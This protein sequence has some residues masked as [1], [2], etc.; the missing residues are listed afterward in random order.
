VAFTTNIANWFAGGTRDRELQETQAAWNETEAYWRAS[1]LGGQPTYRLA[2]EFM[3]AAFEEAER[4]PPVPISVA[5]S[6]AIDGLLQAEDIEELQPDWGVVAADVGVAS[7][8][9]EMLVR[10]RRW[11]ADFKRMHAIFRE[12]V[13]IAWRVFLN[14]LPESCYDPSTDSEGSFE[15]P[16][17]ELIDDPAD[18]IN[19]LIAFA[20]SDDTLRY[21][22]FEKY[23]VALVG[24]LLVA[25]GLPR[26][27]N[28]HEYAHRLL[29]PPDQTRMSARQLVEAYLG[30]TPFA[31]VFELPVPFRIPA[32]VRF[33]HTH[34]VGGILETFRKLWPDAWGVRME[35]VLR[36]SL[37]ALL[38]R[39][40]S[41]LPDILRLYADPVFRKGVTAKIRNEIVRA[42]W[43][44][45]FDKYPER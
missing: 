40:R 4:V 13:L 5:F 21:D 45:E 31:D 6:N 33:E 36:N 9:R 3:E 43:K 20:Y 24:N 37:Y 7:E 42:F 26:D 27:A 38:E 17:V 19:S 44:T 2:I 14:A 15:V 35:H 25:S 34:I 32:P 41:T 12:R 23:R 18:L 16:L 39:E 8:M 28:P 22:L 29:R 1:P 11:S 30:G 10:R